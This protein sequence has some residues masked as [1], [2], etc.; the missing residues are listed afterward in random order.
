M[1]PIN[2]LVEIIKPLIPE[3]TAADKAIT[4][5]KKPNLPMVA[6]TPVPRAQSKAK[7]SSGE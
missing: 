2:L 6:S 7:A 5:N 4:N 1:E 3:V